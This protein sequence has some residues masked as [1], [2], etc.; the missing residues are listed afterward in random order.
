MNIINF[1]NKTMNWKDLRVN[2]LINIPM[3]NRSGPVSFHT[4]FSQPHEFYIKR[5]PIQTDGPQK[6]SKNLLTYSN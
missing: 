6:I 2:L 3:S 4:L 1:S 5:V